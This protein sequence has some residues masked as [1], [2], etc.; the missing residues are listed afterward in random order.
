MCY[1]TGQIEIEY[2]L[3]CCSCGKTNN[4]PFLDLLILKNLGYQ[5]TRNQSQKISEKNQKLTKPQKIRQHISKAKSTKISQ[6]KSTAILTSANFQTNRRHR[7][8]KTRWRLLIFKQVYLKIKNVCVDY[9][10]TKQLFTG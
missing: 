6:N 4:K 7:K 9:R 8:K 2:F 3:N 10:F 1:R 5:H